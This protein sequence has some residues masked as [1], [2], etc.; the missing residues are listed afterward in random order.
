MKKIIHNNIVTYADICCD[1]CD[2]IYQRSFY[3][4]PKCKEIN[5]VIDCIDPE[6]FGRN[7]IITC[8]DCGQ[9][10]KIL[11]INEHAEITIEEME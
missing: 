5:A 8:E 7:E 11:K 4:C 2:E 3:T 1:M 6:G 9:K 10:F